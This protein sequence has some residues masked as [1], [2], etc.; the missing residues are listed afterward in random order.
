[1]ARKNSK[2][3][4]ILIHALHRLCIFV[5]FILFFAS[6]NINFA[7]ADNLEITYTYGINNVAKPGH[8]IPIELTVD[9]RGSQKF[10]GYVDFNVYEANDSVYTYRDEIEIE[11]HSVVIK[12]MNVALGNGLNTISIEIYNNRDELVENLR[13]N[14]DL[15]YF[16]NKLI[17]GAIT[18]N[19][20]NIGYL[21]NILLTDNG[22]ET[23]LVR[24]DL[25]TLSLNDRILNHVD[26]LVVS[27]VDFRNIDENTLYYIE[28]YA[29]SGKPMI[30]T[31]N[32]GSD[33]WSD[34]PDFISDVVDDAK[35]I[36]D[37]DTGITYRLINTNKYI[38]FLLPYSLTIR[39]LTYENTILFVD[40]LDNNAVNSYIN[41]ITNTDNSI[42]TNDYFKISELLNV[43]DKAIL[44]NIF[45]LTVFVISYVLIILIVIYVILR[46]LNM[47]KIYGSIVFVFS[48]ICAIA[49]FYNRSSLIYKNVMLTYISIVDIRDAS[50][51][52]KA[53]LNFRLN[54][55]SNFSF[56]TGLDKSLNPII[57]QTREP[58]KS[59]NFLDT[60]NLKKTTIEDSS[61]RKEVVVENAKSFDASLFIYEN[62]SYLN[63]VYSIN[64]SFER[65][66]GGVTGRITNNMGVRIHD[67]KL[68]MYGKVLDIGDIN[69]NYSLSLSRA[70]V[71][72]VPID[73]NEMLAD[74]LSATE[75]HDI[76]K[77]YLDEN[78]KGYYDYALLFGFID[79]NGTMD[80]RS[81]SVGNVFGRTLLVTKINDS[82]ETGI[83][84]LCAMQNEVENIDGY[85]DA[86]LN[87]IRGDEPVVNV[88]RFDRY[89]ALS[90][91]Y[92]ENIDSYD[93]GNIY[94]N[95]P[96]YG[97]IYA[98]NIG[99]Y[100]Y[101]LI[102]DN[103]ILYDNF[104]NYLTED[105]EIS[106]RF[107]PRSRD[108]LYR[109]ISLPIVRAVGAN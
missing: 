46:N 102:S 53:F 77:Y 80:I 73:N 97:D 85:Y 86:T 57:R 52:E 35:T 90:K 3:S 17:I 60:R 79:D 92:F 43:A 39:E 14:I 94:S 83:S 6:T 67:A 38:V 10:S 12:R 99:T 91:I 100:E 1:M 11:E 89:A 58:I 45:Y 59:L 19:F 84:D 95:V 66:D 44:P 62:S 109:M 65:F 5:F 48:I 42:V 88:Y 70:K 22:I 50:T 7:F 16:S 31:E 81:S 4:Y 49:T 32:I 41:R 104:S 55:D 51:S 78:V 13:D 29:E 106:L 107:V 64:C 28:R 98:Y 25:E 101:D 105:N 74:I 63:D 71:M 56:D 36:D 72:N 75:N 2:I 87:S 33:G 37:L 8:E 82:K 18:P 15:S 47:R 27:D 34:L 103:Q 24:I 93:S 30:V 76:L 108:P 21:D 26:M 54:D 40:I 20:S 23:K 9:N 96:F 69:P 61:N 68:L